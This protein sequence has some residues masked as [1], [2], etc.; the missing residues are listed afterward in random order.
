MREILFR[1]KRRDNGEWVV[2]C[3]IR[4]SEAASIIVVDL[5]EGEEPWVFSET[6]GQY[7]GLKDKNGKEI[8]EG[9]IVI[10]G[11]SIIYT[12]GKKQT[13]KGVGVVRWDVKNCCIVL[14][15]KK[16]TKRLTHKTI[17]QYGIEVIGNIHD[18]PGLLEVQE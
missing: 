17:R 16:S 1:G 7:I 4:Y 3:L 8:Y 6:V 2:G 11:I 15:N 9:D 13:F 5:V 14:N 12:G 10:N 18:N